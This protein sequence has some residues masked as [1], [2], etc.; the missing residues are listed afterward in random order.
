METYYLKSYYLVQ[1]PAWYYFKLRRERNYICVC[2]C[3]YVI[4]LSLGTFVYCTG[5][6]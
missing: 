5:T 4:Q 2:I 1:V 3:M 6:L